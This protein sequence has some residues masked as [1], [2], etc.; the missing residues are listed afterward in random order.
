[1]NAGPRVELGALLLIGIAPYFFNG[2]YNPGLASNPRAFWSVEIATWIVMPAAIYLIGRARHLFDREQLGL[3][4]RL[5]GLG[6]PAWLLGITMITVIGMY[7]LDRWAVDW[8]IRRW[9]TNPGATE[10]LY[11]SQL[12]DP[13]PTTGWFRLLALLHFCVSAGVVEEFYYRGLFMRLF[14]NSLTAAVAFIAISTTAFT[15][16]HWEAGR[17]GMFEAAIVGAACAVIY[18]AT[19][20]LWPVI[21]AHIVVDF[22]W[23]A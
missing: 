4:S 16:N 3:N 12:P 7:Y 15:V 8:G 13:G 20:N 14:N 2:W 1:M 23:F 17:V 11:T 21:I 10:F 22:L 6:H 5:R 19:R 18:R 9:P